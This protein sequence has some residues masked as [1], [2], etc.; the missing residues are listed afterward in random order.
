MKYPVLF[1]S[2]CILC[3][4]AC[5]ASPPPN[6]VVA[7]FFDKS[8]TTLNSVA[9]AGISNPALRRVEKLEEGLYAYYSAPS[10]S[11]KAAYQ[12]CAATLKKLSADYVLF[13]RDDSL[14][15]DLIYVEIPIYR[16]GLALG[17]VGKTIRFF[18]G[19]ERKLP[20]NDTSVSYVQLSQPGWYIY[21]ADMR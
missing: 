6:S 20:L 15:K 8:F 16:W 4:P 13:Y 21:S 18:P 10:E 1:A 3:F 17:G 7:N 14:V 19:R 11:D 5:R 2:I 12:F 9:Q